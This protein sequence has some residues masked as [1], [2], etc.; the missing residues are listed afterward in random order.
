VIARRAGQPA[1]A[2]LNVPALLLLSPGVVSLLY[3]LSNVHRSGG[4]GRADGSYPC[5]PAPHSPWVSPSGW[6]V[7]APPPSSTFG[8][9]GTARWA[10]SS[11][12]LFLSGAA[13]N[14]AM[15][16]L[17]LYWQ[18][19]R[20]ASPL[21]AGLL[22]APQGIGTLLSRPMTGR[23]TDTLG[24][25]TVALVGVVIVGVATVP[26]ALAG[27]HTSAWLLM[28][29]LVRGIGLGAVT[30]PV[31]TVAHRRHDGGGLCMGGRRDGHRH[32]R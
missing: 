5:S 16:L 12:L 9:C 7:P 13:L 8:C 24:A 23:Y 17:P 20:G 27:P 2:R 15:L 3:G 18:Q 31:K 25:R 11:A 32:L 1:G 21:T 6:P 19:A 28:A 30:V 14:G 4:F 10:S 26:F 29:L 22:L